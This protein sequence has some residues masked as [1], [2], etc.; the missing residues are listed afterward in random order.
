MIWLTPPGLVHFAKAY[1]R[2]NGWELVA[3]RRI[4]R[5]DA[6]EQVFALNIAPASELQLKFGF[7]S[8]RPGEAR[9]PHGG[10]AFAWTVSS[11][12]SVLSRSA[13]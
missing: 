4:H 2:S 11:P 9:L 13:T 5:A 3:A 1:D 12:I 7:L 8:M 6:V 10:S